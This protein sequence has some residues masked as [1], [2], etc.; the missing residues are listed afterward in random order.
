MEDF[1]KIVLTGNGNYVV[2]GLNSKY[3]ATLC[4]KKRE[5]RIGGQMDHLPA[6]VWC[7]E[8]LDPVAHMEGT[9]DDAKKKV[10][11][12]ANISKLAFFEKKAKKKGG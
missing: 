8:N 7:A 4:V 9:P 11:E 6:A 2:R 10:M 5:Y 3:I 1:F 12:L